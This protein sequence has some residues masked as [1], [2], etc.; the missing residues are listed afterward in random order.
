[1]TSNDFIYISRMLNLIITLSEKVIK[2]QDNL[3]YDFT[4]PVQ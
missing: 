1:M 4:R 2:L 3:D